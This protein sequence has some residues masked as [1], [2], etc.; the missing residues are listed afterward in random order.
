MPLCSSQL[1]KSPFYLLNE[2]LFL[3]RVWHIM[4]MVEELFQCFFCMLL[5]VFLVGRGIHQSSL[6][7]FQKLEV[8]EIPGHRQVQ[9]IL[10]KFKR[11]L[12]TSG[13]FVL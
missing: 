2:L 13:C 6:L 4:N 11:T 12:C 7:E 3:G 8:F 9:V 10:Q 1:P 5:C